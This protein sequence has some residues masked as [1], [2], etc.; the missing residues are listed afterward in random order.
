[1]Y[2]LGKMKFNHTNFHR[3]IIENWISI[4]QYPHRL[5]KISNF[6][7]IFLL[8][9]GTENQRWQKTLISIPR[10]KKSQEIDSITSFNETNA[11][12]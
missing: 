2:K 4:N 1:M 7:E 9:L 8:D 11:M 12:Q 3:L 6:L 10:H 5:E